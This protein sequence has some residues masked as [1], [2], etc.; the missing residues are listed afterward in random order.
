[1]VGPFGIGD[2]APWF[3]APTE[4]KE[5]FQF[6]AVGGRYTAVCFFESSQKEGIRAILDQFEALSPSL[7]NAGTHI[8]FGVTTDPEDHTRLKEPS[9]GIRYARDFKKEISAHYR[10]YRTHEN[11]D[12]EFIPYTMVLDPMMRVLECFK[13]TNPETHVAEVEAFIRK[14]PA[15]APA[16]LAQ[17]QAPILVVPRVFEPEFCKKL[18]G[19]YDTNGGEDSGFMREENGK[20]V[21]VINHDAKRRSD[22]RIEDDNVREMIRNRIKYRLSP[23]LARAFQFRVGFMERYLVCCYK[24]DAQRGGFFFAHRDNTTSATKHRKFA[25][26][27][28]LNA[29]EYEGGNL[30]FPEYGNQQYRAPTGG[31][32]VFSCSLLHEALPVTS[33]KRYVFLPFLHDAAGEEIRK[34]NEGTLDGGTIVEK[35]G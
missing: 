14:Q 35:V 23:M 4:T 16:S 21:G 31:A 20:T 6:S 8:F 15:F 2:P 11:G 32:V 7:F 26:T 34:E 19:L 33:G 30:R 13:I 12:R 1:M 22:Y 29:E 24:G 9:A 28:N 3:E 5:K 27:I 10:C 17:V 18:I 25:V